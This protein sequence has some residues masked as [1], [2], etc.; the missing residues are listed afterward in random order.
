MELIPVDV[1]SLTKLYY[2]VG[3]WK[4]FIERT[5]REYRNIRQVHNKKDL[6]L[7][8]KLDELNEKEINIPALTTYLSYAYLVRQ[9]FGESIPTVLRYDEYINS[10]LNHIN[11]FKVAKEKDILYYEEG[12]I[13]GKSY[14]RDR[15][16]PAKI[17]IVDGVL[18]NVDY[19][20]NFKLYKIKG[21]LLDDKAEEIK[22]KIW[23]L[24][25]SNDLNYINPDFI[26]N[27]SI[28][29]SELVVNSL[30]HGQSPAFIGLQRIENWKKR[31]LKIIVCIADV[32]GGFLK[33]FRLSQPWSNYLKI[34][35]NLDAI[36]NACLMDKEYE[37]GLK[38]IT[39]VVVN[40]YNGYVNICSMESEIHWSQIS[41][42]NALNKFDH[43]NFQKTLQLTSSSLEQIFVAKRENYEKGFYRIHKS[44]LPGTRITFELNIPL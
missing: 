6:P 2:S 40:E 3:R 43:N 25:V 7:W 35:S 33:A 17:I 22:N 5:K 12:I 14:I 29:S 24:F 21:E 44:F 34:N 8:W 16:N 13:E 28:L 42:N 39:N 11:F 18:N 19:A 27:L 31:T 26:D 37:P 15:F 1:S 32:G 4:D 20:D 10:F 30:I 41:W 38:D 9:Y 36:Y 23:N